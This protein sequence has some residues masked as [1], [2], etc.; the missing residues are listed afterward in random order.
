MTLLFPEKSACCTSL[1]GLTRSTSKKKPAKLDIAGF[2]EAQVDSESLVW[3][4]EKS[5]EKK[6]S[7]SRVDKP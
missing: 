3:R 4:V 6:F 1:I 2:S 5:E 7:R